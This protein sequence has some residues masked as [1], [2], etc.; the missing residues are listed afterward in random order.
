MYVPLRKLLIDLFFL[1]FSNTFET[2]GYEAGLCMCK[3]PQSYNRKTRISKKQR[4][5]KKKYENFRNN[6]YVLFINYI[7]SSYNLCNVI[8]SVLLKKTDNLICCLHVGAKGLCRGFGYVTFALGED[9]E[10]AKNVIKTFGGRQ[11]NISFA[12]KRPR[13]EKRKP[14]QGG[15]VN[16]E[17]CNDDDNESSKLHIVF[18]IQSC[19]VYHSVVVY[20]TGI[21]KA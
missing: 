18:T 12:D 10:R 16:D 13:H 20:F 7:M 2:P 11:L 6:F 17:N 3:N 21:Q 1:L 4:K 8:F 15:N 9:A 19:R 14:K 5:E